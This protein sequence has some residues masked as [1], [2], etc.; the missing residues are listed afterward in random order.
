[1]NTS[2]DDKM[3]AKKVITDLESK[4]KKVRADLVKE[5]YK[6]ERGYV[7]YDLLG[8]LRYENNYLKK[9]ILTKNLESVEIIAI[10]A[11]VFYPGSLDYIRV[12]HLVESIEEQNSKKEATE[13]Y[14]VLLKKCID[15]LDKTTAKVGEGD[16]WSMGITF[17]YYYIKFVLEVLY[18]DSSEFEKII[19]NID[20]DNFG[21]FASYKGDIIK[22]IQQ[23][24]KE[25]KK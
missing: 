21:L 13:L 10:I 20:F 25:R 3:D 12:D 1:M 22:L 16:P 19:D 8:E 4:D 9:I 17:S 6:T 2:K 14:L 11:S 15:F 7:Y 24:K 23:S 5:L 18:K